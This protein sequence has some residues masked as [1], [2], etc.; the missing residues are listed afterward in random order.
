MLADFDVLARRCGEIKDTIAARPPV[1]IDGT[2]QAGKLLVAFEAVEVHLMV[3]EAGGEAF[4]CLWVDG[5]PAVLGDS[6][7][8]LL[9]KFFGGEGATCHTDDGKPC[10]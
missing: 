6:I 8:S 7:V 2:Q 4:P 3:E 1:V 10:R 9:A 5:L